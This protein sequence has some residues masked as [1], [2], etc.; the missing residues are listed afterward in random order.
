[1]KKLKF[2]LMVVF[3]MATC[4]GLSI[5]FY[6]LAVAPPPYFTFILLFAAVMSD[7]A[8]TVKATDLGG[9]EGNPIA[10]VV[11]KAVGVR[12]GGIL[13]VCLFLIIAMSM[14][15]RL[16]AYQ[17][18]ALSCTYWIVPLNNLMVIHRLELKG[19]KK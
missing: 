5:L 4:L 14:W 15:W 8:T 9:K 11:F 17:Q 3:L 2:P 7:Y 1:M 13:V 16:A 18:L 19:S 12:M 10:S 6:H